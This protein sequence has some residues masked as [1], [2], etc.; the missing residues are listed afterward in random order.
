MR[1][2]ARF[3]KK[4]NKKYQKICKHEKFYK[5]HTMNCN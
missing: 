3:D 5:A 4:K 2:I 1:R